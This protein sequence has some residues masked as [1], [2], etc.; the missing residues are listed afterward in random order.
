MFETIW[1]QG[2]CRGGFGDAD[3]WGDCDV[4]GAEAVIREPEARGW[5]GKITAIVRERV[6]PKAWQATG[7][8]G[9]F[10]QIKGT[11]QD[12]AS[13]A[14]HFLNAGERFEGA[15]RE[16]RRFAFGFTETFRQ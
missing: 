10:A 5:R 4:L 9:E 7:P 3:A 11:A 12:N 16:R 15:K 6:M 2:V 14:G 8:G 1:R 13:G